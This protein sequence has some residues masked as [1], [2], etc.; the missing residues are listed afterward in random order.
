[1]SKKKIVTLRAFYRLLK[2]GTIYF[3][4]IYPED[5]PKIPRRYPED[6]P[7]IESTTNDKNLKKRHKT[8]Q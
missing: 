1:M 8:K 5:I 7:T 4:F 6:K 3:I 2:I